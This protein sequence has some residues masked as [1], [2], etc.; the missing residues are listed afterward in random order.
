MSP[1]FIVKGV[2]D[3]LAAASQI[4][5]SAHEEVV[6]LV[7]PSMLP[8]SMSYGFVEKTKS[9][10][11]NG[12]VLRGITTI[13]HANLSGARTRLNIGEDLRHSDQP[14][15]FF[16]VVGDKQHSISAINIGVYDFTLDTPVVAF[17]S[18]DHAC[19]E[20]L[21]ASFE[22]A[23]VQAVPAEERIKELIL[24]RGPLKADH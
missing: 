22:N 16:L 6:W 4:L 3:A 23:W 7:P 15:E 9:F 17:R 21:L 12:G 1:G 8:I 10:V 13:S 2:K 19:A 20:Y 24:K 5:E 18:D 11:Q 14:Y